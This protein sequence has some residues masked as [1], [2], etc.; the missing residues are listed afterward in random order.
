MALH[1]GTTPTRSVATRPHS[2]T[3]LRAIQIDIRLTIYSDDYDKVQCF[4]KILMRSY[5]KHY[6]YI[7]YRLNV[8]IVYTYQYIFEQTIWLHSHIVRYDA[9]RF[10]CSTHRFLADVINKLSDGSETWW[11][12]RMCQWNH[13]PRGFVL[14]RTQQQPPGT[15]IYR[16]QAKGV[17]WE[18]G[19]GHVYSHDGD[20][21]CLS[22]MAKKSINHLGLG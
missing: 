9:M 10:I 16:I 18:G 3:N 21:L 5:F 11:S 2:H 4:R 8:Y 22:M 7:F 17:E 1:L 14:R 20:A 6:K 19:G 13:H 12:R 15:Y